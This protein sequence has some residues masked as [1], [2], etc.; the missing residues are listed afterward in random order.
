MKKHGFTLIELL[1]VIAII[2]ILAAMLLPALQQARERAHGARCVSN[3]KQLG[4]VGTLYMND[5]RNFW[6]APNSGYYSSSIKGYAYSGW[7]NRLCSAKYISGT[8]PENYKS[9]FANNPGSRPEWLNCPSQQVKNIS[10][11]DDKSIN[12]QTYAAI[13]NNNT[14]S[15]NVNKDPLWG[16]SFNQPGFNRGFFKKNDS[17]PVDESVPLSKRVWFAD[18]KS[19]RYGTPQCHLYS[20]EAVSDESQGGKEY[21]RFH[22]AHNGRGNI[23]T[24]SGSVASTDSDSM[25]NYYQIIVL[26]KGLNDHRSLSLYYYSSPDI[27]CESNGG[28][29][30]MSP[31]K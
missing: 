3:L 8:Y 29:G 2:A 5:N 28:D 16:I 7:L 13:Y 17:T 9:L 14:G 21:A 6:P 20:T 31:Y 15:S 25:K 30:H 10:G 11:N 24:W 19:Y 26:G 18:G 4:T 22:T 27:E 12:L 1:V 23:Y